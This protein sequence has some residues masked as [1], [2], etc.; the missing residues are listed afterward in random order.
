VGEVFFGSSLQVFATLMPA[1]VNGIGLREA[2]AVALYTRGGVPASVAVLIPTLGFLIEM[3]LSSVGGIVFLARRVGY[4]VQIEVEHAEHEDVVKAELPSVPSEQWPRRMRGLALGAGAGLVAGALWGALEGWLIVHGSAAAPDYGVLSY[5]S[6][7]YALLLGSIGAG[8]GLAAAW[9]GR[10]LQREAL[11][12]PAAYAR[13]AALLF[14]GC[15]L[16]ITA[17][18]IRRDYFRE[19][20]VWKSGAGLLILAGCMLGACVVYVA[21]AACLRSISSRR[22]GSWLLRSWGSPLLAVGLVLLLLAAKA[23]HPAVN[24]LARVPRPAAPP[25]AGNIV[26]IVVDT[27][28]ADRLPSY[29]FGAGT[30]PQLDRFAADALRF[31]AAFAN[32]SWT[33]PSF[34]SLLSGRYVASHRTMAKSDALPDEVV[35]LPEALRG[36]GYSTLGIVTNFNVAPFFNFHQGFDQYRYLEPNFVLGAN[37]TAAKLLVIQF[38]RQHIETLRAKSGRVEVG[39]AYQ[40]ARVVNRAVTEVLDAQPSAPFFLFVAYMDPHDPYYPHP[41][42]GTAYSRAAHPQPEP[43][44]APA[45]ERLYNGEISYWDQHFGALIRD[46]KRR[47]LYDDA[48]IVVTSDHGEEF[49]DHG[50]Y[51]HGTTLY[52]E[53][54]HVPLFL[55]LPGNQMHGSVVH[56]FV[57]SIDLMPSL[58]KLAGVATPQGVQGHDLFEG[59]AAVFA[60]ESHEGNVLRSLR[61]SRA[62]TALKLITANPNNPRG[63]KPVELYRMDQDP[64]EKV[65]LT[66]DEPALLTF[67]QKAL[68]AQAKNAALGRAAQRSVDLASDEN[69]AARLRALGYAGGDKPK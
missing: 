5:G 17:F 31:D 67:T 56:H 7:A 26:F 36:A 42:D 45:L 8:L 28:R 54:V 38:L 14:A 52:D 4:H 3:A 16:P 65:D 58:L 48:T 22:W 68:D 50:G 18:R 12:E 41:Y 63:L 30:T 57:Q 24:S 9:S 20:L 33:R 21:L 61:L 40:D 32:A 19:E 69:A 53:T 23:L 59:D 27:L 55:K 11:P 64:L 49:Q 37:D 43:N 39:S 66:N 13:F 60:E 1:S 34:A 47:G 10:L 25:G 6:A 46:L 35:T 29:G 2:T 44:E 51:W 62:G 15:A